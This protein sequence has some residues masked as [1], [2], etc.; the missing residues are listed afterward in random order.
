M[1][2]FLVLL[3][4]ILPVFILSLSNGSSFPSLGVSSFG[5]ILWLGAT[6]IYFDFLFF[7]KIGQ[8]TSLI[9][10]DRS[11]YWGTPFLVLLGTNFFGPLLIQS[12]SLLLYGSIKKEY[13]K[14]NFNNYQTFIPFGKQFA[15][16]F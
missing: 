11:N 12:F 9:T 4:G 14:D 3:L 10:V 6:D 13:A 5:F 7:K 8:R 2:P 16:S 15:S 1:V